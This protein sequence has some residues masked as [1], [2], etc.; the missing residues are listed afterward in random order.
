M[1]PFLR[2]R[3]LR[4]DGGDIPSAGTCD[5]SAEAA[6]ATPPTFKKSRRVNDVISSFCFR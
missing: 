1:I 3:F 2:S 6:K 5:G 4:G